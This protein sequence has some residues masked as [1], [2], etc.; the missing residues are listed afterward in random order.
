MK[1]GEL[2]SEVQTIVDD[3]LNAHRRIEPS[4]LIHEVIQSHEDIEGEDV[5]FYRLCAVEHVRD[6][7]RTV[8]RRY[9]PDHEEEVDADSQVILPGFE[10]LQ[11]A[12][13]CDTPGGSMLV[14]LEDMTLEEIDQKIE[15]YA[16]LELGMRKHRE[17]L[18]RYRSG[19]E[20]SLSV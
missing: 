10:R 5:P 7:V 19:L 2:I 9:H 6:T 17:E 16:A 12:Y 15:K 18:I 14:R 4:W 3:A 20:V 1:Q 8:L 13:F 11:R